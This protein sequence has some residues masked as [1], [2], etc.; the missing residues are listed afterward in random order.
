MKHSA[1][2]AGI[3]AILFASAAAAEVEYGVEVGIGNSDNI[4]RTPDNEE[5]ETILTTGVDLRW[6]REEGLLWADVDVD[7][8]YFVYQDDAYDSEVAGLASADLRLRFAPER[9]EWVITDRF[10]Q[11][12]SDPFVAATPDT[13]ENI[14][15]LST[16]PDFMFRLGTAA[17]VTLFGR[18]SMTT[19]EDSN[20]DDE[21]ELFGLSIGRDISERSSFAVNATTENVS[22]DD[23]LVGEEFD[24]RS[25]FLSYSA[26]GARTRI[27]A[28]AGMSQIDRGDDTEDY[29]LFSLS[30]SRDLSPRSVLTVSGGTRSSD[31]ASAI[32]VDDIFGGGGGSG[33]P[34]HVSAADTFEMRDARLSWEFSAPRTSLG[35]SVGYEEDIYDTATEFDRNRKSIGLNA[36]RQVTPRISI[37]AQANLQRSEF[38]ETGQEED[39]MQYGIHTS[40][41]AVG[42]LFIELD[43]DLHDRD[44]TVDETEYQELRTFLRFA[45]RSTGE[46][47]AD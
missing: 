46:R 1:I 35:V 30:L 2:A 5:S 34:G 37:E 22:F 23:P 15:Y 6:L 10:G 41:N 11:T 45:W 19:Y 17:S 39:E 33:I 26:D 32:G 16:G 20:F 7:L 36:R 21:R 18:Y 24:R 3:A 44:S 42:R 9:F 29:P 8:S 47:Q 43:V 38:D 4:R 14:N 31:T 25:Y 40:W 13:L 27:N 28:Q 12:L